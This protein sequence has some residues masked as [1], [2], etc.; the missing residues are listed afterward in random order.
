M[1][2]V[3]VGDSS[4]KVAPAT[5]EAAPDAGIVRVYFLPRS[6]KVVNLERLPNAPL[7]HEVTLKGMAASLGAALLSHGRRQAN[8]A[9]ADLAAVG[10]SIT[11]AFVQSETAPSPP[12]PHDPR[13]LGEAIV[14]TWSNAVMK[15]TFS[16]GGTITL[17]M[18]GTEGG[19]LVGRRR[20]TPACGHHRPA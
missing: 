13:P 20:R 18:L 3:D 2:F 16:E 15:V 6:R 7:P 14:G 4:F 11:A 17:R 9:R 10:D 19:A 5:Y 12:Q 8:E 1:Y